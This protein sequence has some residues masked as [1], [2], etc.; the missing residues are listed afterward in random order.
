[1]CRGR[2][3]EIV[4]HL[5]DKDPTRRKPAFESLKNELEVEALPASRA[6]AVGLI[7]KVDEV[8][9]HLTSHRGLR[10]AVVEGPTGSGKS[11]FVEELASRASFADRSI[12]V[13][14]TAGSEPYLNLARK[15]ISL[16]DQYG[17]GAASCMSRLQEFVDQAQEPAS[18]S[19]QEAIHHDLVML[20]AAIARQVRL[21]V[22]IE[23]IDRSGRR[24]ASLLESLDRQV[25]DAEL[26]LVVTR[27]PG[28][29]SPRAVGSLRESLAQNLFEVA[30]DPL[31][32]AESRLM[33]SFLL[34]DEPHRLQAERNSGGHPAFLEEFCGNRST[35]EIPKRVRQVVSGMIAGLPAPVRR[36]A[37]VLSIFQEPIALDVIADVSALPKGELEVAVRQLESVG[38]VDRQRLSIRYPAARVLLDSKIPKLRRTELHARAYRCL[39]GRN[40]EESILADH[41]FH[42]GLLE[43]AGVLYLTLANDSF[44]RRDFPELQSAIG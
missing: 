22:V 9:E 43:D 26:S 21:L 18:K 13:C 24:L 36:V 40:S 20:I 30:V 7:L 41:A 4:A 8:L 34:K 15:L 3:P 19:E 37:E 6:P 12:A 14:V 42:G 2:S 29:I 5:L 28:G 25:E 10:V 35:T 17:I 31:T 23:D 11:R 33:T 38:L 32:A 44:A 27:R 1:M 39:R 16:T